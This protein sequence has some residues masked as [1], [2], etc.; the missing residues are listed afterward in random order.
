MKKVHTFAQYYN[1]AQPQKVK[2]K[3]LSR[4]KNNK[5]IANERYT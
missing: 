3:A 5:K 1:V 4:K 2:I